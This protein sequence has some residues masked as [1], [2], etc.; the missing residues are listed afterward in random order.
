[1]MANE[2]PYGAEAEFSLTGYIDGKVIGGV[3]FRINKQ[4]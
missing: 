1:M 2:I 3:N 4:K